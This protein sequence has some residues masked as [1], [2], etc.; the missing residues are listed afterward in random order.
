MSDGEEISFDPSC[1]HILEYL[2][3][4]S[5]NGEECLKVNQI[6][7]WEIAVNADGRRSVLSETH[8]WLAF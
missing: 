4:N 6:F 3:M 8:C 7:G 2:Q 5:N 1:S